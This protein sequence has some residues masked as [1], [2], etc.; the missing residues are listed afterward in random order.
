MM[1][2]FNHKSSLVSSVYNKMHTLKTLKVKSNIQTLS[3]QENLEGS[4]PLLLN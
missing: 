1:L 2:V 3:H 4:F